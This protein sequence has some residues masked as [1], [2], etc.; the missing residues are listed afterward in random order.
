MILL[1]AWMTDLAGWLH[2]FF[3]LLTRSS[4]RLAGFVFWLVCWLGFLMVGSAG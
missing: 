4:C 1:A 3:N 2:E